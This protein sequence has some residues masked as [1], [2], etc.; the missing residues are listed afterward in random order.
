[1]LISVS[2]LVHP[3]EVVAASDAVRAVAIDLAALDGTDSPA[4]RWHGE[5]PAGLPRAEWVA[6]RAHCQGHVLLP[7]AGEL[8][9]DR[10]A[11]LVVGGAD[12]ITRVIFA[13]VGSPC[14]HSGVLVDPAT[15][16]REVQAW[17]ATAGFAS[18]TTRHRRGTAARRAAYAR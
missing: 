13:G 17:T 9:A 3:F 8:T 2:D 7:W 16:V 18:L 15:R 5:P 14:V 11:A 4:C 1:V 10:L 12:P 6:W